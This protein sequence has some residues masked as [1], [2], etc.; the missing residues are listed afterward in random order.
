M[1]YKKR[2]EKKYYAKD[3]TKEEVCSE[4]K[5]QNYLT[6]ALVEISWKIANGKR[7]WEK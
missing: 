7:V 4:C 1:T 5:R 6:S 3:Q 2:L